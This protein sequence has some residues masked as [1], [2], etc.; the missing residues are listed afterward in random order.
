MSGGRVLTAVG[1]ILLA[2]AIVPPMGACAVH[3]ARIRTAEADVQAAA[4]LLANEPRLPELARGAHVWCG[5][6]RMPV[7]HLTAAQGWTGSPRTEW[8]TAAG[9]HRPPLRIRGAIATH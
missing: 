5:V 2:T 3:R 9:G 6:G 4:R 8:K 1:L 7:A